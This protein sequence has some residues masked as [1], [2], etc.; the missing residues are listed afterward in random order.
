[1]ER[2]PLYRGNE[3][4]SPNGG[5][6]VN[7]VVVPQVGKEPRPPSRNPGDVING[8]SVVMRALP[9][10]RFASLSGEE[11]VLPERTAQCLENFE[12]GLRKAGFI[13][14]NEFLL[15]LN[16]G[17]LRFVVASGERPDDVSGRPSDNFWRRVHDSG[18]F[19]DSDRANARPAMPACLPGEGRRGPVKGLSEAALYGEAEPP[20][21]LHY[22]SAKRGLDK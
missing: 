13:K 19:S 7:H 17:R 8:K 4:T 9:R 22:P 1:M 5:T 10:S 18:P 21:R 2:V 11:V 6:K 3:P 20:S 15:K 14:P 16:K 12:S